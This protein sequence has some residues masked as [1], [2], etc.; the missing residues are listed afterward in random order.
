VLY[1]KIT[2]LEGIVNIR[3]MEVTK[4]QASLNEM[5][6]NCDQSL[7]DLQASNTGHMIQQQEIM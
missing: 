1:S 4:L 2:E 7:S 6:R 5:T 3:I